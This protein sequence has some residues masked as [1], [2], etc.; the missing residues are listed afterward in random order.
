MSILRLVLCSLCFTNDL[1]LHLQQKDGEILLY[2]TMD[3]LIWMQ[4][5]KFNKMPELRRDEDYFIATSNDIKNFD[6]FRQLPF[7]S[8]YPIIATPLLLKYMKHKGIPITV[9]EEFGHKY[10]TSMPGSE[11]AFD[12]L[13]EWAKEELDKCSRKGSYS[14]SYIAFHYCI[15]LIYI[16]SCQFVHTLAISYLTILAILYIQRIE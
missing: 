9:V 1:Q 12:E 10:V 7:Y 14:Y 3:V 6:S 15:L 11:F 4:Y 2:A 16:R 13:C 5:R 8:C